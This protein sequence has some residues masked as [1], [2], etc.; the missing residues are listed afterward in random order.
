MASL[1]I[2]VETC[3]SATDGAM[4][5]NATRPAASLKMC[6]E[7]VEEWSM[8]VLPDE[9]ESPGEAAARTRG[10]NRSERRPAP[11]SARDGALVGGAVAG[12]AGGGGWGRG[13]AKHWGG[14]GV[15]VTARR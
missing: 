8:F 11:S 9:R 7:R 15:G 12:R 13:G 10:P 6:G 2:C 4:A 1:R 14:G 5:A 3:A